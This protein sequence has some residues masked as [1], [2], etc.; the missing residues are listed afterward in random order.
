MRTVHWIGI[1]IQ[2]S[3]WIHCFKKKHSMSCEL[4]L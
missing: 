2:C 1:K 3:M 4:Y